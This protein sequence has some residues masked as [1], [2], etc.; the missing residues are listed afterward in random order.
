[1]SHHY[2][3]LVGATASVVLGGGALL[4]ALQAGEG[5]SVWHAVEAGLLV[6]GFAWASRIQ[7]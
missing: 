7:E 2:P 6:G 1:M 3:S 4:G 5:L